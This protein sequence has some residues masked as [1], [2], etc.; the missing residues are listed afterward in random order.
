MKNTVLLSIIDKISPSVGIIIAIISAVF[1]GS[2]VYLLIK[3]Y[4][5]RFLKRIVLHPPIDEDEK[6]RMGGVLHKSDKY[7]WI[8]TEK[9]PDWNLKE[10]LKDFLSF[11]IKSLVLVIS[12]TDQKTLS[13]LKDLEKES[14]QMD[15]TEEKY[16]LFELKLFILYKNLEQHD[17]TAN[18][19]DE[20]FVGGLKFRKII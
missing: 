18:L 7:T 11:K 20:S 13:L 16:E 10:I 12:S 15:L 14:K 1:I 2:I 19:V 3:R 6:Q 17:I 8:S 4:R 9:L 5:Y